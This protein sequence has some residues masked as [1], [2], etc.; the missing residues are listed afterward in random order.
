ML[1]RFDEVVRSEQISLAQWSKYRKWLS[2]SANV[3]SGMVK[4]NA[5]IRSG[6]E[7]SDFTLPCSR[8]L[9]LDVRQSKNLLSIATRLV[10]SEVN[11]LE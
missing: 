7:S 3:N 5:K 6:L 1:S 8:L 2:A 9:H 4:A 11:I 10:V